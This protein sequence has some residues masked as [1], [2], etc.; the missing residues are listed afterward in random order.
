MT[1]RHI[2]SSTYTPSPTAPDG[3]S[4][5]PN[6]SRSATNSF[7]PTLGQVTSSRTLRMVNAWH[8][9]S[10][11]RP[12]TRT[13][14]RQGSSL[15]RTKSRMGLRRRCPHQ[16]IPTRQ[17]P[18]L[19]RWPR[20]CETRIS[21]APLRLPRMSQATT[22]RVVSPPTLEATTVATQPHYS[23]PDVGTFPPPGS[24][25]GPE[26][27]TAFPLRTSS[28]VP[29]G[30]LSNAKPADWLS[31]GAPRCRVPPR[32]PALTR[33]A[34]PGRWT[35]LGT[36]PLRTSTVTPVRSCS[37]SAFH[38]T[39]V[40]ICS[41]ATVTSGTPPNTT[42]TGW[43][44]WLERRCANYKGI[45]IRCGPSLEIQ[46]RPRFSASSSRSRTNASSHAALRA[47]KP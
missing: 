43:R 32:L 41:S 31:S 30:L 42:W 28:N 8:P 12:T 34:P 20:V 23:T 39:Y 2:G 9:R 38:A 7:S 13:A 1:I 22:L 3:S 17:L 18:L 10:A 19:T 35:S 27:P 14:P 11:A 4:L 25:P 26:L 6:C 29:R 40:H 47:H 44:A 37:W 16:R 15:T 33:K 45:R 36:S 24:S 21:Q 46:T 5:F